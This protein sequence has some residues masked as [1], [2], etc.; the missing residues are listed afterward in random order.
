MPHSKKAG[1]ATIVEWV[2]ELKAE[3]KLKHNSCLD[4]GV[5]EGA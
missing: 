5:G 3:N 4:I 1:K 2:E